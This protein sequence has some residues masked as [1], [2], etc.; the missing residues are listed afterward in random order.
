MHYIPIPEFGCGLS[1][2]IKEN[3]IIIILKLYPVDDNVFFYLYGFNSLL[4]LLIVASKA[5][6]VVLSVA[7]VNM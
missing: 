3:Y 6:T 4:L 1:H 5:Y 2:E 7:M